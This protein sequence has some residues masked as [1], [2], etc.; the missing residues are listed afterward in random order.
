MEQKNT[1]EAGK[2][3]AVIAY[4]TFIGG[5]VA[6]FMNSEPKNRFAAFHIRQAIGLH[7]LY[8]LLVV[9]ISGFNSWPITI[10]FWAFIFVLWVYGFYGALQSKKILVPL[11]GDYFQKWFKTITE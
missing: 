10:G 5:I 9:L 6:L 7:L 4:I 3:T 11:V 1:I 8:F 2:T